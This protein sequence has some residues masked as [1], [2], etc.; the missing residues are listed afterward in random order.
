MDGNGSNAGQRG[1]RYR[2]LCSGRWR[3]SIKKAGRHY[4][5]HSRA[6]DAHNVTYIYLYDRLCVIYILL[7]KRI[8]QKE[9]GEESF[10]VLSKDGKKNKLNDLPLIIHKQLLL[11]IMSNQFS[12]CFINL[13][14][15]FFD[16]K[17]GPVTV[18]LVVEVALIVIMVSALKDVFFSWIITL[19]I[20]I[21]TI[22]L[23]HFKI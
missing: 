4:S 8:H 12:L 13:Q 7:E 19:R 20:F 6:H 17:V 18:A 3:L 23:A 14:I 22:M 1:Y 9:T 2:W 10:F 11:F 21:L 15:G 16:D 5:R